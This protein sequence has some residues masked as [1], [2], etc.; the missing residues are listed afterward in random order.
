MARD[1]V[2]EIDAPGQAGGDAVRAIR[3]AGQEAADPADRDPEHERDDEQIAGRHTY[4]EPS[5]D[6]LDAQ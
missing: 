3:Q 6:P 2:A 1:A 4:A 5:L